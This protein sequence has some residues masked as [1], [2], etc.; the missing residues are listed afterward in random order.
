MEKLSGDDLKYVVGYE[1]HIY[2]AKGKVPHRELLTFSSLQYYC[3]EV[4]SKYYDI[5]PIVR[6]LSDIKEEEL[7]EIAKIIY[8]QPD[9]VK[10]KVEFNKYRNCH[11]IYR[12][13]YSKRFT[14]CCE[15]GEI[16]CYEMDAVDECK[17]VYMN[18]HFVTRYL[19]SKQFDLYGWIKKGLAIDKTKV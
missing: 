18:Q 15:S 5:K 17:D 19:I 13:H 16:E 12:R 1:A 7:I 3:S 2:N 10:W 6:P 4:Y 9:S 14:F 11:L 8:G